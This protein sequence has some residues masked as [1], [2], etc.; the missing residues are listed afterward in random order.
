MK[1]KTLVSCVALVFVYVVAAP[2]A[3]RAH[4]DSLD[5]PVVKAAQK[6]LADRDI[7]PALIWVR[8]ED[9][10]E[11]RS[12]F[13]RTL[14]VRALGAD[15][16]ALA[17]RFFFETIVRLHRAGEGEP[18]TGL[19]PA[20][21]D[22]GPVIPAADAAL[23]Q[24]SPETLRALMQSTLDDG[25]RRH[26]DKALRARQFAPAD[27]VAGRQFVQ[28]YVAYM[29]YIERVYDAMTGERPAHADVQAVAHDHS[30]TTTTGATPAPRPPMSHCPHHR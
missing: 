12:A 22:L 2:D 26:F 1:L 3:A 23:D 20:G 19:K 17:D 5:G 7:T 18:Y 25:L 4:C 13:D 21:R 16:K 30:G 9:E 29:H 8:A 14:T 6:A 28:S 15:A 27:V 10:Q 11:V 24:Q